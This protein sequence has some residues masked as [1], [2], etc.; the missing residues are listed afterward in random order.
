MTVSRFSVPA[1]SLRPAVHGSVAV[2]QSKL[3]WPPNA[4]N[5]TRQGEA[6]RTVQLLGSLGRPRST[7]R[8]QINRRQVREAVAQSEV[9]ILAQACIRAINAGW[10]SDFE[11]REVIRRTAALLAWTM[12]PSAA[13]A[14]APSKDM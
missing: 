5:S 8:H 3:D 6:A 11:I 1:D 10:G 2:F 13:A 12:P 7:V 14:L 4:A 9:E